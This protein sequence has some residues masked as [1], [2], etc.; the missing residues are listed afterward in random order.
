M[1]AI[2]E[3]HFFARP[4]D[5]PYRRR[6]D[7]LDDYLALFD[8]SAAVR[9]ESSTTYSL[10]PRHKEVPERIADR[11][12]DAKFIYLVRDPLERVVSAYMHRR[13]MDGL[14]RTLED[15]IGDLEDPVE[16]RYVY[17]SLYAMQLERYLEIFPKERILIVD[18]A[19]LLGNRVA[20]LAKVFSFLDVSIDVPPS[21]F[22]DE[23]G[24]SRTRREYPSWYL[25]VRYRRAPTW[26]HWLPPTPRRSV[27]HLIDYTLRAL[28]H[29]LWPAVDS[30]VLGPSLR[31][32]LR[33]TFADDVARLR[34]ITGLSFGTWSV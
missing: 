12:P 17:P 25:P 34:Q 22:D 8:S 7:R 31:Q 10:Y 14:R 3:P 21:L 9:G 28:E 2:K 11:V 23:L 29:A 33:V 15:D 27:R 24:T 5:G 6:V 32:R 18:H 16:N 20:C 30:P 4:E 26:A 19:D 1:S 13:S